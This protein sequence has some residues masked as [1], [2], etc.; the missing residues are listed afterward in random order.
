MDKKGKSQTPRPPADDSEIRVRRTG[1][2]EH[3]QRDRELAGLRDMLLEASAP[4]GESEPDDQG[5][6]P[7]RWLIRHEWDKPDPSTSWRGAGGVAVAIGATAILAALTVSR[8][9]APRISLAWAIGIAALVV[10]GLCLVAH[11][12]VNRGRKAKRSEIIEEGKGNG[13]W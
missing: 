5:E 2:A 4:S 13:G 12:D 8:A 11:L 1:A 10:A 9:N 3:K 6:D 7:R